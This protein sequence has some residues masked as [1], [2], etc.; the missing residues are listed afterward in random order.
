MHG[1]CL[2]VCFVLFLKSSRLMHCAIL[3]SVTTR[4]AARCAACVSG[5]LHLLC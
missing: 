4:C 5:W 3:K 1:S 2:F